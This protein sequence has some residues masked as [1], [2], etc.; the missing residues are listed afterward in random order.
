MRT[1]IIIFHIG[2]LLHSPIKCIFRIEFVEIGTLVFKRIKISLHWRI[3]MLIT[4]FA[5]AL[6]YMRRF[7]KFNEGF[8]CEL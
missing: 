4:G 8:R 2:K 1:H 6:C 3:V 7:A 5:H